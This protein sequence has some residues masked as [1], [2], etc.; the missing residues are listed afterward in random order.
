M[1]LEKFKVIS[2]S[3]TFRNEFYVMFSAFSGYLNAEKP[4]NEPGTSITEVLR[5]RIRNFDLLV[6]K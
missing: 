1:Y 3:S 5:Q 2:V 4:G 6:I